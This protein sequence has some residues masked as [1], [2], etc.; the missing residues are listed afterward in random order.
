MPKNCIEITEC[1]YNK[2]LNSYKPSKESD[3]T[4]KMVKNYFED[5][6]GKKMFRFVK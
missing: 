2:E 4:V 1:E 5:I 6:S 3:E